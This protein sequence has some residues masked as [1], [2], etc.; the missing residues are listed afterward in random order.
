MQSQ[1]TPDADL[2]APVYGFAIR[3]FTI[4][5][6]HRLADSGVLTDDDRVELLE[7]FISPKMVHSPIH[8]A[9][10]CSTEYLIRPMLS[11]AWILRIQSAISLATSE[12]EPDVVIALGPPARY[13]ERHPNGK[14]IAL[15]IEIA[16][17]SLLRDRR[18]AII[19]ASGGVPVYWIVNLSERTLEYFDMP[20]QGS[21]ERCRVFT[22][23]DKVEF[24]LDC[25]SCDSICVS[26]LFVA[27]K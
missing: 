2:V 18:K 5:E 27:L 26:D 7:G 20:N 9:T 4:S 22:S 21:Y 15:V 3:R 23:T 8:D 1:L 17:T 11:Q 16:E 10:V 12:P 25:M 14:D 19:Y 13:A 24:G 6:Y